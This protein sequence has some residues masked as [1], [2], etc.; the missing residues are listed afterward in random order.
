MV[1]CSALVGSKHSTNWQRR[2][3]S[4]RL[5]LCKNLALSR[6]VLLSLLMHLGVTHFWLRLLGDLICRGELEGRSIRPLV[7]CSSVTNTTAEATLCTSE[8][9]T[10]NR[11]VTLVFKMQHVLEKVPTACRLIFSCALLAAVRYE[12]DLRRL[13]RDSHKYPARF[14]GIGRTPDRAKRSKEVLVLAVWERATAVGYSSR[15]NI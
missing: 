5:L 9:Q 4:F 14:S 15:Q 8:S 13:C 2:N 1:S 12:L 7:F 11:H 10:R 6:A 3:G